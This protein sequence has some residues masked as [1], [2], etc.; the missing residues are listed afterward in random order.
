MSD[1]AVVEYLTAIEARRAAPETFP[2][3]E[4][5]AEDITAG[6]MVQMEPADDLE[7]LREDVAAATPGT[8][9]NIAHLE[10]GFI[11]GAKVYGERHAVRYE[12]WIQAGVDP[13]V[14]RRAGIEPEPD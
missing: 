8:E 4:R 7:G 3:P 9:A 12:G 2:Q 13:D 6:D 5:L 14:L 1:E 10:E 11:A